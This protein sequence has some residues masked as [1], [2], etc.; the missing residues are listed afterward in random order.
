VKRFFE[1]QPHAQC[2]SAA[3]D[4]G[5]ESAI[6]LF[7]MEELAAMTAKK[8]KGA[9]AASKS[10]A[11][12]SADFWTAATGTTDNAVHMARINEIASALWIP[13]GS[14]ETDIHNRLAAAI[15]MFVELKPKNGVE[16]MLAT[17]MVATHSAAMECMRRA[18]IEGQSFEGRDQNLKHAGKLMQTFARQMEV[19]DKHRGKGQQKITVEHVTVEAGGQAI[20]GNVTS[21]AAEASR[22]APEKPML[23][24]EQE[25]FMPMVKDITPAKRPVKTRS[26]VSGSGEAE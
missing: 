4:S 15:Q 12:P 6:L 11:I 22:P 14:S 24:Q 2:V 26:A 21:A 25:E 9:P 1:K 23:A 17:Q 16:G 18:M 13:E 19:L 5:F 3:S 7:L 8:T 10:A 20:V